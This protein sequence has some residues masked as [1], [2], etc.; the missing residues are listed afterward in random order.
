MA[1]VGTACR[2]GGL[3]SYCKEFYNLN[4]SGVGADGKCA[5]DDEHGHMLHDHFF[6]QSSFCDLFTEP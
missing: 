2:A 4:F 1:A 3:S 5:I 6:S